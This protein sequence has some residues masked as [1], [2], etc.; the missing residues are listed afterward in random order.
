VAAGLTGV[1]RLW[2]A[3][4]YVGV[5]ANG[6]HGAIAMIL[7]E[8]LTTDAGLMSLGVIVF[9]LGMSVFMFFRFR[10]FMREDS[11]SKR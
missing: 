11:A 2:A 5:P 8:L 7:N 9:T 3:G 6:I 10:A 1:N 4:S